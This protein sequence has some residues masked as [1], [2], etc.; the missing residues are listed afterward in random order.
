MKTTN[1]IIAIGTL[2]NV[3]IF[4]YSVLNPFA[5]ENIRV[6]CDKSIGINQY[7]GIMNFQL[8]M[9]FK[10]IGNKGSYISKINCLVQNKENPNIS[11]KYDAINLAS[12][13]Y[14]LTTT[15]PTM[16]F[17]NFTL[18][19]SESFTK[20]IIFSRIAT[21][22]EYETTSY[23]TNKIYDYLDSCSYVNGAPN[24]MD[25][26]S[27]STVQHY[28]ENKLANINEGVYNCII[29]AYKNDESEPFYTNCFYFVLY[30]SDIYRLYNN[31]G[32]IKRGIG[33]Y[34]NPQN[35]WKFGKVE[36]TWAPVTEIKNEDIIERLKKNIKSIQQ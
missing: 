5:K 14:S 27:F 31:L 28:I 36:G 4:F 10:N 30:K 29:Q 24:C 6:D 2:M 15:L 8:Y 22:D 23:F 12:A 20:Y 7:W 11:F 33:I 17:L 13:D 34:I 16:P 18:Q 26:N 9:D 25:D 35:T 3:F 19:P 21:N 32:S 1:W